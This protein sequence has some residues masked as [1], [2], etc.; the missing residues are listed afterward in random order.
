MFYFASH[1]AVVQSTMMSALDYDG[2]ARLSPHFKVS[3]NSN[4]NVR[5]KDILILG[6]YQVAGFN[7]LLTFVSVSHV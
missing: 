2:D 3:E 4:Y 5:S 7:M 6:G 1:D